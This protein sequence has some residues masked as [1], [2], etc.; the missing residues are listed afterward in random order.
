MS[1]MVVWMSEG[2]DDGRKTTLRK[3]AK[4]SIQPRKA[5]SRS[6]TTTEAEAKQARDG[7][8]GTRGLGDDREA[9]DLHAEIA[10][11]VLAPARPGVAGAA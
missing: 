8:H 3:D 2:A 7:Q 11:A 5:G 10:G 1:A 9:I 6:A 4:P